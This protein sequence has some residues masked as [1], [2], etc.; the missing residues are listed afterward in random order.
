MATILEA[1]DSVKKTVIVNAPPAR[2]FKV[3]TERMGAW[4][5]HQ[6]SIGQA[7]IVDVIIEPGEG[8]RWYERGDDG[9]ESE[10]G[11]VLSWNPPTGLVLAWQIG[12]DWA[13]H[14]D[15]VT[16]VELKFEEIEAGR[17]RVEFEHR[18]LDQ[19]GDAE[20]EIRKAFESPDGWSGILAM[21]AKEAEKAG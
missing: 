1:T 17:T 16:E 11:R 6:N 19:F 9:S 14:E 13:Y 20:E 8:G 18:N 12:G 15:L 10:W 3:F 5:P 2:A 7:A 21:F 4:W